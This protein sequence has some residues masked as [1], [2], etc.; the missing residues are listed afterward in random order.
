MHGNVWEWCSDWYSA[1][2]GANAKNTDP[3]GPDSGTDRVLR[4]GCWYGTALTCRSAMRF[5]NPPVTR[6]GESG[7]RVVA[8]WTNP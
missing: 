5:G 7:F 2:Y 8:V 3:Q 4:G 1:N 6:R